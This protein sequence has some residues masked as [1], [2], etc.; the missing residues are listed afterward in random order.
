MTD[1]KLVFI[2]YARKDGCD[3]AERL[4]TALPDHGF[5]TWRDIRGIDPAKDFT[6]EIERA[7][8]ASDYVVTCI[9]PDVVERDDSFVRR[10]IQYALVLKKPVLVARFADVPPPIHVVNHTWIDFFGRAWDTALGDLCGKLALDSAALGRTAPQHDP[11]RDYVAWLYQRMVRFLDQAVIRLI[12]IDVEAD[13]DK[14]APPPRRV[15]TRDIID[16]RY[17]P[18]G[19]PTANETPPLPAG[20]AGRGSA[21]E[22]TT[23]QQAFE[24]YDGRVL[25]LGEP[26][27]GK[28]V[29]LMAHARDA[30]AARLDDPAAPLPMFAIIPTWD[31]EQQTPLAMWLA[32]RHDDLRAEAVGRV[33]ETGG[34]LLLLDGLDELGGGDPLPASPASRGGDFGGGERYDPRGRFLAMLDPLPTSPVDGWGVRA[35]TSTPSLPAGR[36][37]VG[38][39]N[40]VVVSCRVEDYAQIKAQATLAGAVTLQPLSDAQI[41]AYLAGDPDLLAAVEADPDLKQMVQTPLIMSL[42]AFAYRDQG[43][44][45]A[46]L[47]DLSASPHAL[48]KLIFGRYV[49]ARYEWEARRSP[50]PLAFTLDEIHA[51]LGYVS[52]ENMLE[53]R[54]GREN[55]LPY[56][57]F[58]KGL[59]HLRW[60]N[61]RL[62]ASLLRTVRP[63]HT[64]VQ[65]FI[66]LARQLNLLRADGK[67]T[68]RF[69]HL[70]LRLHFASVDRLLAA[71]SDDEIVRYNVVE[72]LGKLGDVRAVEPLI[73]ALRDENMDV[74]R[75]AAEALGLIGDARAVEPLITALEGEDKW[76]CSRV[77]QALGQLGDVRAVKPLIAALHD[78]DRYVRRRAIKALGQIGEPAVEPLIAALHTGRTEWGRSSAAEALG[79]IDDTRAVQPLIEALQQ[80]FSSAAEALGQLGDARAVEPLIAALNDESQFVRGRT[81]GALGLLGDARAVGP[82]IAALQDGFDFLDDDDYW[83]VCDEAAWA[84]EQIGTPEALDAVRKWREEQNADNE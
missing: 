27:A 29:T 36:G 75:N 44:E 10:E 15:Q 37:G 56:E 43:D 42:F 26:G 1:P 28:S 40:Q 7:I 30:A 47:R 82:L 69:T 49:K 71:L 22:F 21:P 51:V 60:P 2:S 52:A 84:L 23:F 65:E 53:R 48:R 72:A 38:F 16:Q 25:L 34:A 79:Q 46:Q 33:I 77:A 81:A 5:K 19:A 50:E 9:T 18:M 58:V 17:L 61:S 24:H 31:A 13:S 74:R 62:L 67:S 35:R 73:V 80:G 41:R 4:D 14:V 3:H 6:V 63:Q 32:E 8:Q 39:G 45:A 78:W 11:F 54:R 57:D 66:A 70:L 20:E 64:Q 12:D 83:L 76:V 55:V 59:A 68:F